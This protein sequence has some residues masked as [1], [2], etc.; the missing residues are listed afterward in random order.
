MTII[1]WKDFEVHHLI[2]INEEMNGNF[3]K[4]NNVIF[5]VIF[6]NFL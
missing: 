3:K 5:F 6:R 4:T 1:K 2:P